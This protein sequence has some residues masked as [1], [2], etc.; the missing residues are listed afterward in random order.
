MYLLLLYK[1]NTIFEIFYD[2]LNNLFFDYT[3]KTIFLLCLQPN[4]NI[5]DWP[6]VI[7]LAGGIASGKSKITEKLRYAINYPILSC[8]TNIINGKICED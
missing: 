6:Y 3:C 2:H 4:P 7:G 8:P 1:E 5:P